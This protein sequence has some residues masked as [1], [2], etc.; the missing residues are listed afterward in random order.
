MSEFITPEHKIIALILEASGN[1]LMLIK[2]SVLV[3]YLMLPLPVR[4]LREKWSFNTLQAKP[5]RRRTLKQ[6]QNVLP[7]PFLTISS[8]LKTLV[9]A[10]L[11][12][13]R[14]NP[15]MPLLHFQGR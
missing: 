8:H 9:K 13:L 1:R 10:K 14:L 11:I 6:F 12:D 4:Q 7:S 3:T 15:S 2:Y 5:Y